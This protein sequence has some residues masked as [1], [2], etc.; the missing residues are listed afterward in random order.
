MELPHI[1]MD[2]GFEKEILPQFVLAESQ[3]D[4]TGNL[5]QLE[6]A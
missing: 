2:C 5:L 3:S 1:G 4:V 6:V